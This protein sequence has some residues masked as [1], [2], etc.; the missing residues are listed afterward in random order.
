VG[1]ENAG[2]TSLA[3]LLTSYAIKNRRQP[4]LVNL[5]PRQG[6]LSVPGSLTATTFATLVDVEEGWG[7]SPI[8]G[9]SA[10]PVKMP[11]CYHFGCQDPEESSKLFKPLVTRLA[12]A[13]G[14]RLEE[15]PEARVSGCIIDT[16][17]TLSS[18]KASGYELIQHI[19][20]EFSGRFCFG[21]SHTTYRVFMLIN[22]VTVLLVLGSER[23]YSEMKRRFSGP[24]LDEPV[25]VIKLDKSGGCVDRDEAYM[26]KFR[27]AQI[28]EYFYGHGNMGLSPFTQLV[29]YNQL[30]I[31]RIN[32]GR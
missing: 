31:Y 11:L 16:P 18:G 20:S 10:T 6:L 29:E 13:T 2:K 28:K 9:P 23:L 5:D 30:T 3:K 17:G 27:E 12:L 4:V 8:S 19:A 21:N 1:P 26:R 7:S 14:S 22:L 32:D 24:S 15:D 25:T